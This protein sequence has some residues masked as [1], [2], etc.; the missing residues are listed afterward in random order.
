M[1]VRIIEPIS[2]SRVQR[3]RVCAYVR[4][5]TDSLSQSESLENQTTYYR[6]FIENNPDYEYIAVFADPGRTG[7]KDN[8]PGFQEMLA[9]ARNHQIDLILTKSISRFARNTTLV[10]EYVRELKAIGVEIYFEKEKLSTFSGDGEL[11]LTVLSSFAQEESKNVSD[12][13]KWRYKRNFEQG[14]VAINTTRFLGYDKNEQGELVVNHSEAELVQRIFR[15]YLA[16]KGSFVIARELNEDGVSTVANG[17]WHS[18]TVLGILKNEKYKG[19]VKLQ[20]TYT[21]DH[22]SKAKRINY[23]EVDS[24]YIKNH[25]QA[26]VDRENWAE[27]QRLIKVRAAAKGNVAVIKEKYLKRYPLTGMLVCSKCGAPLRR[28]VWNSKYGCRKIVWQCS[29]YVKNGKNTCAGTTIEDDLISKM[30]ITE[31]TMVEEVWRHG[32]KNYRYSCQRERDE[33]RRET[34]SVEKASGGVL[35]GIDRAG[36]AIIKLRGTS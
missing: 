35:P 20:K 22:L 9:L 1:K 11:M 34:R 25:H 19:D 30:N 24:Y 2:A 15:D 32:K 3:K 29:T 12:N 4:V 8:R 36:R 13:V 33:P 10:L 23:G 5:S 17:K 21:K 26:I 31:K 18:G 6:N 7:T 14:K 16:G 28:R 27:V